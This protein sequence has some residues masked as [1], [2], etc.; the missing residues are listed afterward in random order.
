MTV[1]NFKK[2][3]EKADR[4]EL[5]KILD[6]PSLDAERKAVIESILNPKSKE[7]K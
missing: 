1:E 7:K 3:A 2:F 6:N 5:Q 4:K